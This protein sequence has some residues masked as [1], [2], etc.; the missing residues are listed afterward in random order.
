MNANQH[1]VKHLLTEMRR[2]NEQRSDDAVIALLREWFNS[3]ETDPRYHAALEVGRSQIAAAHHREA[4]VGSVHHLR[5]KLPNGGRVAAALRIDALN[6]DECLHTIVF[7]PP[8]PLVP[9]AM[10]VALVA[11]IIAADLRAIVLGQREPLSPSEG[12]TGPD[13]D[14]EGGKEP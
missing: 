5:I 8:D 7:A 11:P 12:E 13:L 2:L 1:L 10:F 6:G 9:P 4:L 3:G 14:T